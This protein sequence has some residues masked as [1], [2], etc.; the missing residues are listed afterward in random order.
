M[1][2]EAETVERRPVPA[3]IISL[4]PETSESLTVVNIKSNLHDQRWLKPVTLR[5]KE[6]SALPANWDSF[7]SNS[8]DKNVI[9]NT[10]WFLQKTM[11]MTTPIPQIVPTRAGNLQLEWHTS[12]YDIEIEVKRTFPYGLYVFSQLNNLDTELEICD[13]LEAKSY[14]SELKPNPANTI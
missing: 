5:L 10:L 12:G 13:A 11:S 1:L 8:I 3:Q 4:A 6:L 7:G 2:C 14:L 9:F